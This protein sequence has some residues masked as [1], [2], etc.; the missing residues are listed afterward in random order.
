[1]LLANQNTIKLIKRLNG[2]IVLAEQ[3]CAWE[4]GQPYDLQI[5]VKG[6]QIF[7]SVNETLLFKVEDL[8]HSLSGGGIALVC[9]EGRIGTDHVYVRSE[10]S[11]R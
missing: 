3:A 1:L 7:G 11:P 10:F 5:T 6:N 8:D 2:E 9:E 4:F